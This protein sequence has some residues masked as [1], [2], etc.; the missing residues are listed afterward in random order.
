MH[1][2][3]PIPSVQY[4]ACFFCRVIYNR[5][6]TICPARTVQGRGNMDFKLNGQ[7]ALYKQIS[8]QILLKIKTGELAP[9][10]RLPTERDLAHT[11]GVAR[12]TVK[13]AYADLAD[14][15]IVE[16]IQG[17]GT[18]VYSDRQAFDGQRRRMAIDMI[19]QLL[20]R[21]SGWDFSLREISTLIRMCLVQRENSEG[22]VRVAAID[23]NPES[24][25]IFKQQLSY[26]P[27]ISLSVFPIDS[28]ILNDNAA[29]IFS[30]FDLILT[31]EIHYEQVMRCLH[32]EDM[33]VLPIS[34]GLSRQTI[35]D[36]STL[37]ERCAMGIHCVSSKFANLI[38]RQVA[39]FRS[40]THPLPVCFEADR[41]ASA[42]F[43]QKLDCVIVNPDSA[44]LSPDL[45][46]DLGQSFCEQGGR[47]IPFNYL[48]DRGSL[49]HVEEQVDRVLKNKTHF[50]GAN[51]G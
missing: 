44:L 20:S 13:K 19:E 25:N 46:G 30:G 11:L 38:A 27:N 33:R 2:T 34:V 15:N 40:T 9:G 42:R 4:S 23:C 43:L 24:L 16:V 21:L 6:Y 51:P 17:S 41:Q 7:N 36:I 35:V 50:P 28:I 32:G 37:P 1:K 31:T 39:A 49:I 5:N 48:I 22:I 8:E 10:A 47:I 26:L 3:D 14:N 29:P 45:F 12:G 18:Y